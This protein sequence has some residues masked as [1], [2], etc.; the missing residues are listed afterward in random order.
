MRAI[1]CAIGTAEE[2][3]F[4]IWLALEIIVHTAVRARTLARTDTTM[5][6]PMTQWPLETGGRKHRRMG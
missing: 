1:E 4:D 2:W 6:W 5:A 3:P